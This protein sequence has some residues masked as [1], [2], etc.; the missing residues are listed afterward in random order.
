MR[1]K[2]VTTF[3]R[4]LAWRILES[5]EIKYSTSAFIFK[6]QPT[7]SFQNFLWIENMTIIKRAT[8]IFVKQV[9]VTL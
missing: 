4:F 1:Y 3:R 2:S 9:K 5:M 8:A 6:C 7:G